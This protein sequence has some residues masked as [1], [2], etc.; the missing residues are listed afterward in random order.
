MPLRSVRDL[1]SAPNQQRFRPLPSSDLITSTFGGR[2]QVLPE[3]WAVPL[4]AASRL[5]SHHRAQ[6]A[7][8]T[9]S[10]DPSADDHVVA[11]AKRSIDRLNATRIALIGEIDAW[12][13]QVIQPPGGAPL[14]TETI[15]SVIDRL[16]IAWVRWRRF[17]ETAELN[18][19]DVD[20]SLAFQQFTELT[21]AFDVLV[22]DIHEG[23]RRIPHW[24][25]LKSY[26]EPR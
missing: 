2:P 10:R 9:I 23:R 20:P 21:E 16:A 6:W 4:H 15:G 25:T 12:V 11:A 14:H 17:S 5:A 13:E 26:R 3:V 8:E 1:P 24:R 18:L 22:L 19:R 7:A